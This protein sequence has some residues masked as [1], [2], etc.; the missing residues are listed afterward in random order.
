MPFNSLILTCLI[1]NRSFTDQGQTVSVKQESN[2]SFLFFVIDKK[3]N[4]KSS[5]PEVLGISKEGKEGKICDLIVY[6]QKSPDGKTPS[7]SCVI[8]CAELKG[9]NLDRAIEQIINTKKYFVDSL[10]AKKVDFKK[11]TWKAYILCHGSSQKD[12]KKYKKNFED[13]GFRN[14][15]IETGKTSDISAFIRGEKR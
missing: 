9:T 10:K 11:I 2:E 15:Y 4:E 8:C 14:Q 13:A 3:T 5:L 6:Y 1:P 7:D 12:M